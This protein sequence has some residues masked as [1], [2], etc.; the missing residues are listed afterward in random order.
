M[1]ALLIAVTSLVAST[2]TLFS[3][4]GLGTLLM[5]V[6][7]LFFPIEVAIGIT[8]VVHLANN[9][10]KAVLVGRQASW[11][12]VLRFG[13]PA[14]I[15]SLIGAFCLIKLGVMPTLYEVSTL[16]VAR[17][18]TAVKGITGLLIFV[19]VLLDLIPAFTRLTFDRRYLPLGGFLSGFFGG[20]SGHQG[21][22]RSMFLVK[23]GLSKEAFIGTGVII[24]VLVD[25]T[26]LLVYGSTTNLTS[27]PDPFL[28][29]IACLS[30]FV[31]AF[32]GARLISKVTYKTIQ[33]LVS[34]L[35]TGIS[36]C[37]LLGLL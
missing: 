35:L 28:V 32:V 8:A 29:I 33:I 17:Q 26:R 7:A 24:A 20:L 16:G 25:I 14:V 27:F 23:A 4:F 15:S 34:I 36:I 12:V 10:F 6:A 5:P 19:F 1:T 13:A 11:G 37:L 9:L 3:G 30:A 2:L 21:A 31:G 18:V 22:L